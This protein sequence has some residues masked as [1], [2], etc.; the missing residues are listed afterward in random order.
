M[1]T[2]IQTFLNSLQG[3]GHAFILPRDGSLARYGEVVAAQVVTTDRIRDFL[4][5]MN[6]IGME[7]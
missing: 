5:S 1:L 6:S 7:S 3:I 4:L 2:A